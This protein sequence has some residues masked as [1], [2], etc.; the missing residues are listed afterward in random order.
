MFRIIF[1]W[2]VVILPFAA[3]CQSPD[4]TYMSNIKGIKLYRQGN[5][6]GYPI[7]SLNSNELL[8][9][10]FDDLD[11]T[12]KNY[13]Y[14]Y[15]LCNS[16]WSPVDLSTFDYIKGFSQIRLNQYRLSSISQTKY[17]HY[18]AVLP[19][20]NCVPSKSGNY[21]LKVFLD[22]DTSKLA[23]TRRV[24][25]YEK[26][27]EIGSKV[28][29]PYN[30]ELF[31]THQKIEFQVSKGQLNVVN[32]VQQ[33]KAVVLQ[34]FRWDNAKVNIPPT[35]IRGNMMEFS[36]EN[37]LVFPAGKEFRWAD[38][39]SFHYQSDRIAKADLLPGN[40]NIYLQVDP[41]RTQMR[42]L[43]FTDYNGFYFI[44]STEVSNPWWQT[45]YATVHFT[46]MPRNN[47][48][49]PG[50]NVFVVGEMNHY[51]LN[52]TSAMIYNAAKGV[53]ETTLYLKQ[54]YYSY[55][56]V[57]KDTRS[58]TSVASVEETDGNYWETENDYTVLIYYRSLSG[59]HDEL[60]GV[61][62]INSLQS[63]RIGF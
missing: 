41:E 9:L 40:I 25:V 27:A 52:D 38:L 55:T 4:V 16:D 29:Q 15:Q 58:T 7:I 17:V 39:R 30:S 47:V 8:E 22:G 32:P 5:Q 21:L 53:Y 33:I 37:N 28:V 20:R 42:Y 61:S 24:L 45:D 14:T 49:Y 19:D 18:Q 46:F 31:K 59:R 51:N 63:R 26:L 57:T 12:V 48:P 60:I 34:N 43:K 23:F 54:G 44:E 36:T 56:Y 62:T 10:H 6:L 35:F 2:L 1:F 3:F 11:G 50:K 13:Y